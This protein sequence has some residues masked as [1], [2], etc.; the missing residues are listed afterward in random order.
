MSVPQVTPRPPPIAQPPTR[1]QRGT[2][3]LVGGS[4]ASDFPRFLGDCDDTVRSTGG[5]WSCAGVDP[6]PESLS[7][8]D[9][10]FYQ[11]QGV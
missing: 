2:S 3:Y 5:G 9:A 4:C 10:S 11:D 6:P 8:P 7:D 1:A